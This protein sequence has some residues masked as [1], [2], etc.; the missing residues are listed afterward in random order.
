MQRIVFHIGDK[1]TGTSS[2]QQALVRETWHCDAVRL[3]YP[4]DTERPHHHGLASAFVKGWREKI[5][6]RF[7]KLAG[8]IREE[9]ANADVVVIS[10]ELFQG[11]APEALHAAIARHLPEHAATIEILAYARPH[12]QRL[13]SSYAQVIKLGH[14]TGTLEQYFEKT[15]ASDRFQMAE[16]FLQW[17]EVFGPRFTLRP[18]WRAKLHHG[19]AVA[20]F[21]H[22]VLGG[23][24]F[25]LEPIPTAN[26]SLSLADLALLRRFHKLLS[27]QH[28]A[29]DDTP[30]KAAL[31][32]ARKRIGARL[33]EH[34]A[35]SAP[36]REVEKLRLHRAL[37]HRIETV[38]SEDAAR[39]DTEFFSGSTPMQDG[40]RKA[41][42]GAMER[43]QSLALKD[44]FPPAIR[45]QIPVWAALIGEMTQHAP[46]GWSGHFQKLL[47]HGFRGL[48]EPVVTQTH[49]APVGGAFGS[50]GPTPD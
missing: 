49:Q 22:H 28:A 39:C 46:T 18:L 1:K 32:G 2:I 37:A 36:P 29:L 3:F 15:R 8:M 40:L 33:G 9:G 7:A 16:R 31:A 48:S 34:L 47:N 4:V 12:A 42:E 6:T 5:E 17:R 50:S 20:D 30:H 14:F 35:A 25:T 21:F 44:H 26:E 23:A 38:Y 41:A 13:L 43:P 19:D 11:V 24:R 27:R 10:S 45:R